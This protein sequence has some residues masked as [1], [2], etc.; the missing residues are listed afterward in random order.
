MKLH[1]ETVCG[2]VKIPFG[3]CLYLTF[4]RSQ[5]NWNI[6]YRMSSTRLGGRNTFG[7]IMLHDATFTNA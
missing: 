3:T 7:Y 1:F 5:L 2:M 6:L 4:L